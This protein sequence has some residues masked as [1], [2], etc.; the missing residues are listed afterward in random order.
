MDT[1]VVVDKV[2]ES[3]EKAGM[4]SEDEAVSTDV[5]ATS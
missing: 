2:A 4:W 3:G 5:L 1:V